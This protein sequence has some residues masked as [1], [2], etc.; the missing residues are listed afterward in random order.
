MAATNAAKVKCTLFQGHNAFP[1]KYHIKNTNTGGE[2]IMI[3]QKQTK[4][5]K[6]KLKLQKLTSYVYTDTRA[7]ARSATH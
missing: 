5:A 2:I 7:R 1:G 4:S 6:I 3:R